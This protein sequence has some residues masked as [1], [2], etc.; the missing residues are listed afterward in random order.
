[1][2]NKEGKDDGGDNNECEYEYDVLVTKVTAK[3][4]RATFTL[5]N[6]TLSEDVVIQSVTPKSFI[7]SSKLKMI[8]ALNI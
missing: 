8:S 2:L 4:V 7:F 3:F 5:L 6:N 1:M